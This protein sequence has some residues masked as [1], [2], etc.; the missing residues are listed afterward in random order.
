MLPPSERQKTPNFRILDFMGFS[1]LLRSWLG[2][3]L[4]TLLYIDS[5]GAEYYKLYAYRLLKLS[6][7]HITLFNTLLFF[8]HFV[9]ECWLEKLGEVGR[10]P[11]TVIVTCC[12]FQIKSFGINIL[13]FWAYF[14]SISKSYLGIAYS[15]TW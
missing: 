3:N 6:S 13:Q 1:K 7:L 9:I 14:K 2:H 5:N 12:F 8:N 4:L 11:T 10:C 15:S